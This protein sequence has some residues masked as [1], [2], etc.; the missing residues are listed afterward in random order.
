M[1]LS[2]TKKP[3]V[4]AGSRSTTSGGGV[5]AFQLPT[6]QLA[7]KGVVKELAISGDFSEPA[8]RGSAPCACSASLSANSSVPGEL[9]AVGSRQPGPLEGG[10]KYAGLWPTGSLNPTAMGLDLSEPGVSSERDNRRMSSDMSGA[11]N[12]KPDGTTP[13]VQVTNTCL[14][15]GQRHNK[16]PIFIKEIVTP[17]LPSP[18]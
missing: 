1:A 10:E 17:V 5:R 2:L 7:G 16:T 15:A 14:L 12:D 8:N 3:V 4:P 6:S 18:I 13:H 9:A 11:L